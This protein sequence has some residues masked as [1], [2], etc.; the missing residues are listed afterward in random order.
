MSSLNCRFNYILTKHLYTRQTHTSFEGEQ[1]VDRGVCGDEMLRRSDVNRG[2]SE[3]VVTLVSRR[4]LRVNGVMV[5]DFIGLASS[6]T[7]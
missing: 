4:A 3:A 6:W 7:G 1:T 5:S 2:D